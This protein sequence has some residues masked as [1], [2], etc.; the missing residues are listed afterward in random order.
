[1]GPLANV[2]EG[3]DPDIQ[4]DPRSVQPGLTL[5]AVQEG[6]VQAENTAPSLKLSAQQPRQQSA[7]S[8]LAGALSR[9]RRPGPLGRTRLH[10][11]G[12]ESRGAQDASGAV[13]L[14]GLGSFCCL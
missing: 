11:A 3:T 13:N 14:S 5:S 10:L 2:V 9:G 4:E 1:M 8:S 6:S 7:A 12:G